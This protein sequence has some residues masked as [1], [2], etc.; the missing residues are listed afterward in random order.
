[1]SGKGGESSKQTSDL[2][3]LQDLDRQAFEE[4]QAQPAQCEDLSYSDLHFAQVYK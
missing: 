1:M 3:E 2:S 4:N